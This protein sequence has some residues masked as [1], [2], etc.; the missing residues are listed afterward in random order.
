MVCFEGGEI[1]SSPKCLRDM[2]TIILCTV[3]EIPM[4]MKAINVKIP[5]GFMQ[6]D[7]HGT[8]FEAHKEFD[9][10]TLHSHNLTPHRLGSYLGVVFNAMRLVVIQDSST[11]IDQLSSDILNGTLQCEITMVLER[12]FN[13]TIM[14]DADLLEEFEDRL[15][16]LEER[17]IADDLRDC[18]SEIMQIRKSLLLLTRHYDGLFRIL[19]E[20]EENRNNYIA[21]HSLYVFRLLIGRVDHL[22]ANIVSLR[23]YAAQV[24]EAYQNQLDIDLNKTMKLFTVITAIFL[25]LTLLVGWYGMNFNMPEYSWWWA[26]PAFIVISIVI[27]IG[28]LIY[29]KRK[30]WF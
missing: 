5:D 27:I 17:I 1:Q 14:D 11:G 13:R 28:L 30:K 21:K 7:Q 22:S 16:K 12:L 15:L 6:V 19:Q 29:F 26:Y 23:D 20:I 9:S 24:R 8:R 25:P 10:F 3:D 2:Q 4:A 18:V